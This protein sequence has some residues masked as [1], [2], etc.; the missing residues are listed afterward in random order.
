MEKISDLSI[1]RHR[2][3]ISGRSFFAIQFSYDD[4][5]G[6]VRPRM[7]AV[8]PNDDIKVGAVECYVIDLN[9]PAMCWRGD[10]MHDLIKGEIRKL[11]DVPP[12]LKAKYEAEQQ[13]S[14]KRKRSRFLARS[15]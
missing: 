5:E 10:Q 15:N 8:V 11:M 1:D 6:T 14:A 12:E 7:L 2:N 9:D 3:G 13:A 4:G